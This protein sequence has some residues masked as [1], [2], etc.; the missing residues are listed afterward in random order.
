[1]FSD[2]NSSV[3]SREHRDRTNPGKTRNQGAK[4]T[5]GKH[6]TSV[7]TGSRGLRP[8]HHWRRS[9]WFATKYR[10]LIPSERRHISEERMRHAQTTLGTA[11]FRSVV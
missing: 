6:I 3:A 11:G 4:I 9:L 10:K 1:M 8:V 5:K 2:E 7:S